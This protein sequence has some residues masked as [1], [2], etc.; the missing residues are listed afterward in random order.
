MTAKVYQGLRFEEYGAIRAVNAS[1]LKRVAGGSP[2][3]GL[4]YLREGGGP[5]THSRMELRATH[6]LALEGKA[7]F[8]RGYAVWEGSRRG[9]LWTDFETQQLAAGR[10]V[11]T[12][13]E[14]ARVQARAAALLAHPVA[15]R[16]WPTPT[17]FPRSPSPGP[18]KSQACPARPVWTSG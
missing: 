5:D 13:A 7:A 1:L 9:Q 16:S 4:H 3:H 18:T 15:G 12:S 10:T 8:R 6:T 17:R 14:R 2:L 11:L